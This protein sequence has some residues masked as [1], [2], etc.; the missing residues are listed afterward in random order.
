MYSFDSFSE[1]QYNLGKIINS[2]RREMADTTAHENNNNN[3]AK[4]LLLQIIISSNIVWHR[5]EYT[6]KLERHIRR[7]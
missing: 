7:N 2:L 4:L 3:M 6:I 5:Q 1:T